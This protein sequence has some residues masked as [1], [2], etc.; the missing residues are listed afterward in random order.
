MSATA[1]APKTATAKARQ[2]AAFCD[3]T[4]CTEDADGV[5]CHSSAPQTFESKLY[6]VT[7]QWHR[8]SYERR[9]RVELSI[10]NEVIVTKELRVIIK[11]LTDL[12]DKMDALR[13]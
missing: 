12:A 9:T 10:T 2:H 8:A 1:T 4:L 5:V 13:Y 3:P 7:A 11:D 6:D